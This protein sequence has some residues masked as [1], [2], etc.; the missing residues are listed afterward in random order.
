M[1]ASSIS[2]NE[3]M[4]KKVRFLVYLISLSMLVFSLK[5]SQNVSSFLTNLSQDELLLNLFFVFCAHLV[6]RELLHFCF[7]RP[8]G[9][10]SLP[11]H[12]YYLSISSW[13]LAGF[14]AFLLHYFKYP[15]F[16]LSSHIKFF[17]GYVILGAG[18]LAQ[19]EY[20][21]YEKRYKMLATNVQYYVFN[22]KISHRMVESFFVLT[23][24]PAVVLLLVLSR[25]QELGT[26]G[27]QLVNDMIYLIALFVSVALVCAKVFGEILKEDTET[28]LE[29]ID[30]IQSGS[31]IVD[32]DL[33]RADELGE[34]SSAIRAMGQEIDQG[35]AKVN[36][37]ND[38]IITTQKEVVYT[39][40][41]IAETRSK[42][43]GNHV[44]RVALYSEILAHRYGLNQEEVQLLKLASPMHDIGK[45]A[46]P[47]QILN[48]PGKHTPEE[49]EV[50]KTH[51][52]IGFEILKNSNRR[53][54]KA[55][56]IV[57]QQHHEKWDG[58]GY[59][60]GLSGETIHIY[61]RITAIA[62]VF[63]A[64]SSD[65]VYKQAWPDDKIFALIKEQSGKHFDPK[66]VEIFFD[67]LDEILAIRN[68]L[69]DI[70]VNN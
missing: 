59:P 33:C 66:L 56:S 68:S 19:L 7:P 26:Y 46:I 10:L 3:L 28:I 48:K 55:A 43:T 21:I 32:I 4:G 54:L 49:F 24:A 17:G 53:I 27:E 16:S 69:K 64:L 31:Y 57:A 51:A 20:S 11:R 2:A 15:D 29:S 35:I 44:K 70:Y 63:D 9:T 40:G 36:A 65:R 34:I 23:V 45:I 6:V 47:D 1:I 8:L 61:G 30:K 62:D 25:Y 50:M 41:E 42:E 60:L 14:F 58:S 39:M 52:A 22:E 67:N 37:L 12:M 13:V 38:E 18:I 5:Y